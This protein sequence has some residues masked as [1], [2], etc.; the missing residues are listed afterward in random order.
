MLLKVQTISTIISTIYI[1]K[2]MKKLS[3]SLLFL[4]GLSGTFAIA[5]NPDSLYNIFTNTRS[6]KERI[7]TANQLV[8][9]FYENELFDAPAIFTSKTPADSISMLVNGGMGIYYFY[10]AEYTKARDFG[11]KGLEFA[12]NLKDSSEIGVNFSVIAGAYLRLGDY[13]KSAQILDKSIELALLRNRKDELASDYN[14]LAA[15]Y[16][17]LKKDSLSIQYFQKSI[18]ISRELNDESMLATALGNQGEKF[19]KLKQYDKAIAVF[20]EAIDINVR[21][22][23]PYNVAIARG[24]LASVYSDLKDYDKAEKLYSDALQVFRENKKRNTIAKTAYE[25]GVLYERKREP[26]KAIPLLNESAAVSKEIGFKFMERNSYKA[27][28]RIYTKQLNNPAMALP[29]LEKAMEINDSLYQESSA[30]QAEE[31]NVKYETA[32]KEA[33]LVKQEA[34]LTKTKLQRLI[35]SLAA[36]FALLLAAMLYYMYRIRRRQNRE[37]TELNA[38]KD[39]LFSIVSHDLKSPMIAQRLAVENILDNLDSYDA[40][41][42][43]A[44]LSLFHQA[45]E[46]QLELLQ[47]LLN[48][49][50]IQTGK[51]KFRPLPFDLFEVITEAA[52]LYQLPAQHKGIKISTEVEKNTIAVADKQMIHTVLRNLIN[53]AV[54]FSHENGEIR[55]KAVKQNDK[56]TVTVQDNGVGINEE[57]L[58][59]LL[60]L[61]KN[62]T[63]QGTKGEAGSGL[64]LIITKEL[65]ERN[66]SE[67]KIKSEKNKGTEVEFVI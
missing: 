43:H 17:Y 65:L 27:L 39:K 48:W 67:L 53:N 19:I 38:T 15:V 30:K 14:S 55:I 42:I 4:I 22:K 35:F 58:K 13:E 54:K 66:G 24:N 50:H 12:E 16:S 37:L 51:M 11:L 64:G 44:N 2:Q 40:E 63:T 8:A 59:D 49:A 29:F 5:Q 18:D 52:D 61:G 47:N 28:H 31:L 60:S 3:L 10:E 34:E 7:S 57:N 25:L 36:I 56:V 20:N 23:K 62:R 45:T 21:N 33:Q 9:F 46:V 41:K 6:A 32:E 1:P 26:A